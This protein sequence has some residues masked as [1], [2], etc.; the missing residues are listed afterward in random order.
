[1]TFHSGDLY[2]ASSRHY[3]SEAKLFGNPY[4]VEGVLET[5]EMLTDTA[6]IV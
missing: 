3:Y 2:S 1:M 5:I 4:H 6:C